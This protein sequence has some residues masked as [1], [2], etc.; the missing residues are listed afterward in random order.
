MKW[1]DIGCR[2]RGRGDGSFPDEGNLR[3]TLAA[4]AKKVIMSA[5]SKD[6]TP[7]FVSA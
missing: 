7:M 5:P 2:S 3:E 1:G 6:D 4:G